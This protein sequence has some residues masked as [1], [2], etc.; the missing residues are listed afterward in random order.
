[1]G[2]PP[3]RGEPQGKR[4]TNDDRLLLQSFS[5]ATCTVRLQGRFIDLRGQPKLYLGSIQTPATDRTAVEQFETNLPLG[6]LTDL[7]VAILSGSAKPGQL[8]VRS[9][10][11]FK[12][13]QETHGYLFQGYLATAVKAPFWTIAH[14][15]DDPMYSPNLPGFLSETRSTTSQA[16]DT[17]T[18]PTNAIHRIHSVWAENNTQANQFVHVTITDGTNILRKLRLE[19]SPTTTGDQHLITTLNNLDLLPEGHEVKV[20]LVTFTASD[21]VEHVVEFEEWIYV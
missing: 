18:V 2:L 1:M 12:E 10:L 11:S 8:Y 3:L 14:S 15:T 4:V 6:W 13:P 9:A 20:E 7:T 5:S 16:E 19:A 21:S 17:H